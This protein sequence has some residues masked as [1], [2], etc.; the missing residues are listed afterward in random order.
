[1]GSVFAFAVLLAGVLLITVAV[2]NSTFGA[3]VRGQAN[4]SQ[5]KTQ[6]G[7]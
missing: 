5:L 2:T 6:P 7:A 4:T 3:A 1:M